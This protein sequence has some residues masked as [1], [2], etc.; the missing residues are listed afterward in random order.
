MPGN[1]RRIHQEAKVGARIR[2][3]RLLRSHSMDP[4]NYSKIMSV[5]CGS[6]PTNRGEAYCS[7]PQDGQLDLAWG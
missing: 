4:S 3:A 1:F 7:R 5:E 2:T 6:H